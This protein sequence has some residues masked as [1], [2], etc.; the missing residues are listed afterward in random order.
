MLAV[1]LVTGRCA[2]VQGPDVSQEMSLIQIQFERSGGFMGLRLKTAVDSDHLTAEE[3]AEWEQMVASAR[4][5]DLPSNLG[6]EGGADRLLYK[7]T[8]VT[9][10]QELT[11]LC[12]DEDA[13]EVLRPL[14]D[15]LTALARQ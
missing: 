3:A 7:M 15:R 1:V 12:T 14:L 9:A 2:L 4:F 5:F 10:E 13:P 8:V 11:V 6:I